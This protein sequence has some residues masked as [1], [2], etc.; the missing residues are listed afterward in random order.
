VTTSS[1][2][3]SRPKASTSG[4]GRLPL[5]QTRCSSFSARTDRLLPRVSSAGQVKEKSDSRWIRSKAGVESAPLRLARAGL[6]AHDAATWRPPTA[7]GSSRSSIGTL[8]LPECR[9]CGGRRG[10]RSD[11]Q[12]GGRGGGT[13]RAVTDA[14]GR[15]AVSV[16]AVRR[17]RRQIHPDPPRHVGS[18]PTATAHF[19]TAGARTDRSSP[20]VGRRIWVAGRLWRGRRIV[21]QTTIRT[22]RRVKVK[23]P[24]LSDSDESDWARIKQ[25]GAG[26]T[27]ARSSSGGEREV[28]VAFEHG[29]ISRHS[30]SEA[31]TR[32]RQ[33]TWATDFSTGQGQA[34]RLRLP[35][36]A[37]VRLS[38][39]PGNLDCPDHE[40]RKDQG[41]L[42]RPT[43]RFT[44]SAG[45]VTIESRAT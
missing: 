11:R 35:K 2:S 13:S 4:S 32:E 38:R 23:F 22:A 14:E 30:S 16:S 39:T 27:R 8:T 6:A 36:G 18:T 26:P 10:S 1:T 24:W 34:Q 12:L 21:T 37:Q 41:L 5:R 28:L 25:L 20:R 7:A 17:I 40:R 29:D 45:Q 19:N 44:S 43:P 31:S 33:T 42:T 9:G 3:A 15:Q